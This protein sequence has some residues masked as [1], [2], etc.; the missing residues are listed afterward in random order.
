MNFIYSKNLVNT[1]TLDKQDWKLIGIYSKNCV[2]W[3]ISHFGNMYGDI[4]T[5]SIYDT[6]GLSEVEHILN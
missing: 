6:L 3:I 2:E 1:V 4:T 5:V